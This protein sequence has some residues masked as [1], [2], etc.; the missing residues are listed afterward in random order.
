[1]YARENDIPY[2]GICLGMQIAMIEYARNVAKLDDA[3][4]TEFDANCKSPVVGLITEWMDASGQ[5][6]LRDEH[7]DLGGTMRLGAQECH[8]E[9]GSKALAMYG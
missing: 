3:N 9:P 2:L 5:K 7:S 6:E 1:Q 8:L 4:S